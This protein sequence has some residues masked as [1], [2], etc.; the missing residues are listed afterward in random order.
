MTSTP[1]KRCPLRFQRS[2]IPPGFFLFRFN[3]S[4]LSSFPTLISY[5]VPP[6]GNRLPFIQD[7]S[8]A[9]S[10]LQTAP[11]FHFHKE[12]L[13]LEPPGT[14]TRESRLAMRAAV[15]SSVPCGL[16]AKR[17]IRRTLEQHRSAPVPLR[18][19]KVCQI[20]APPKPTFSQLQV[21]SV[22]WWPANWLAGQLESIRKTYVM[23]CRCSQP[24]FSSLD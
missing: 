12:Q 9:R 10:M 19:K 2:L 17:S 22:L 11:L 3:I 14:L 24:F 23:F 4:V 18:G 5:Q 8:L 21:S 1:N 7:R 15:D 6:W 16:A 20:P 13:S